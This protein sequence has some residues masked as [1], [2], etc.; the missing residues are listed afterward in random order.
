MTLEKS[1]QAA[2]SGN[3]ARALGRA[4]GAGLLAIGG[5]GASLASAACCALPVVFATFGIAGGTW[6]L[7]IAV[8]AG[9]WQRELLWGGVAAL[10]LALLVT[11]PR[12]T[13]GCAESFCATT[14]FRGP[15][16]GLVM[17]G[18]GLAGLALAAG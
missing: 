13:P 16:I 10:A 7:D 1:G 2:D 6:M 17:L 9:P 5:L 14:G 4:F 8:V 15:L 11:G 12:G 3:A 18:G